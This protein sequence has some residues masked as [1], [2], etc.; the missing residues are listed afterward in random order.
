MCVLN[1][2]EGYPCR[3]TKGLRSAAAAIMLCNHCYGCCGCK[4]P[5]TETKVDVNRKDSREDEN[6]NCRCCGRLWTPP[7][8]Q[9]LAGCNECWV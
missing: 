4:E 2:C 6:G 5:K 3:G 8:G 1:K 9:T 7:P